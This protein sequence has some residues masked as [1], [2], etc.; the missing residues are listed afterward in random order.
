MALQLSPVTHPLG[1][2]SP[3]R[4]AVKEY[5]SVY[6]EKM[7]R[8]CSDKDFFLKRLKKKKEW[9]FMYRHIKAGQTVGKAASLVEVGQNSVD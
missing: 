4:L 7:K 9:G 8:T 2:L 1:S 6:S 5:T 3:F